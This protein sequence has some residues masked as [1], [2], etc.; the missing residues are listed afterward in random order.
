MNIVNNMFHY[1]SCGLENIWLRNGFEVKETPYGQAVSIHNLEGLHD[2]I[3]LA[4]VC[5]RPRLN[6][7]EFR[8]LR[9]ELDLPQT[10][11]ATLLGVTEGTIRGWER[12]RDKPITK[13]PDRLLRAIYKN[14]SARE[15]VE[16]LA[17]LD[18]KEALARLELE[19]TD[20]NWREAA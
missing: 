13:A 1:S 15:I 3:G 9:K 4:L 6:G 16:R 10:R 18:Q 5:N 12:N 2:A 14:E 8:F 17:E 11:L 20:S 7:A 19:E